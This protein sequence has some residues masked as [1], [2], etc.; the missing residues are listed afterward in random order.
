VSEPIRLLHFADVHI[1]M[2]N[3]GTVDPSTGASSRVMDFLRRLN[4]IVEY[5]EKNEA[6]LAI[7]AGDAFKSSNPSPTFQREFAR[8]IKR[9]SEQCPVVLLVGNHDIPAISQRASSVEIFH[10]LAVDNVIVGRADEIHRVETKRGT[11]QVATVPYPVRQRLLA[12][13]N[14]RGLNLGDLDLLLREQVDVLIRN[15][16]T[17][18]DTSLPAVLTGHFTVQGAQLGSERGIM[19]GRDVAVTLGTLADPAWD[20]VALGHIHHHQ[21]MNRGQYPP[22]VY[23]GSIER[24]DF[25]EENSSKGFCW[26][27]LERSA[28][29]YEFVELASRPFVTIKVDARAQRDPTQAVL[30]AIRKRDLTDAVVRVLITTSPET[31]PQINQREIEAALGGAAFVAAIQRELEYPT[32]ARLG[33]ERPEGLTPAELLERYL[34]SKDTSPDRIELLKEYADLLFGEGSPGQD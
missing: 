8:R 31:D 15:L 2:E 7:F 4:D 27:A 11:V 20:Y 24:I 6:D 28:T 1:G 26:V 30:K 9:L 3:Y 12:D 18:V 23:S 25:G 21:D 29:T 22:V 34:V 33:V 13:V 17:Q 16:A 19:L 10:T 32:R 14:S 5:A